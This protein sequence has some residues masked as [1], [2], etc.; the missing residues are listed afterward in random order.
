[1]DDRR[2]GGIFTVL[3]RGW[4]LTSPGDRRDAEAPKTEQPKEE[5][6]GKCSARPAAD[7]TGMRRFAGGSASPGA[8]SFVMREDAHLLVGDG[9]RLARADRALRVAAHLQLGECRA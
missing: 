8:K 4:R 7:D 5:A 3:I 2:T 6:A 1:V 9:I